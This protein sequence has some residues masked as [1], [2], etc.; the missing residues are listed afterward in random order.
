MSNTTMKAIRLHEFGGP[1]VLRYEDAPKP[2]AGPGEVI[3]R[4][5]TRQILGKAG[6]HLDGSDARPTVTV[7]ADS[8]GALRRFGKRG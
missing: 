6:K 1:D 4:V 2:V 8:V 3:V 7:M 5:H